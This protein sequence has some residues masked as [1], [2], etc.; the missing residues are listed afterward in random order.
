VFGHVPIGT[1]NDFAKTVGLEKAGKP[2]RNLELILRGEVR[3]LDLG[4]AVG[5]YF[6]NGCGIGFGAEV[7]RNTFEFKRLRGFALYFGAVLRTFKTFETPRLEVSASEHSQAGPIMMA[8]V[9]IGKTAGGGFKLTPDADP[10][11]GLLDICLIGEV[12]IT[13][14]IRNVHR[15]MRGTHTNLPPVTVFQTAHVEVESLE[16]A[17]PVH[18]D[19]ELRFPQVPR[20][21]VDVEPASLPALCAR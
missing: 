5:E 10:T 20:F 15:I 14:F 7:V 16:G 4:R 9:S 13:Y 2:G 19:G 8:E 17:I 18:L 21:V 12:G 1:G 11:D 6:V 3:E